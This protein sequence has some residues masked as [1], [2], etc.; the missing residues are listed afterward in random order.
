MVRTQAQERADSSSHRHAVPATQAQSGK[1]CKGNPRGRRKQI[2]VQETG[3]RALGSPFKTGTRPDPDC[4]PER[5]IEQATHLPSIGR[6]RRRGGHDT[7]KRPAY[8]PPK[9]SSSDRNTQSTIATFHGKKKDPVI[10]S[11]DQIMRT[12]SLSKQLWQSLSRRA[13]S[14]SLQRD[15]VRLTGLRDGLPAV[16]DNLQGNT[17]LTGQATWEMRSTGCT[18]P[19]KPRNEGKRRWK[20]TRLR[21]TLC[22][23]SNH[24]GFNYSDSKSNGIALLFF[25]WAYILCMA[26]LEK[27]NVSMRYTGNP[28]KVPGG[29][30]HFEE[31]CLVVDIGSVTYEEYRWWTSILSPG[32]EWRSG[33]PEQPVWAIAYTGNLKFRV[34]ARITSS[35]SLSPGPPS[36]IQA[37]SF[38]SR[39]ASMYNLESQALLS[40]A[41]ALTLPLHNETASMVQLPKPFLI[42]QDTK[43][44]S[45]SSIDREY[46]NLARYMTLSSNPMFLSSTL[47]AIFWEPGVDCNLVSPWCDPII[48]V[49]KPLVDNDSLEMLGHVLALRRP[50]IAPLWYGI[51]ACGHTKTVL[52]IIPFLQN[53]H[54]PVPSRPIPEVAAWT[55]SP[56]SFLDLPGSGP[57]LQ[58]NYQVARKDVWRLRH[59]FWDVEPEGAPFRNPPTCPWPPFGVMGVEELE[60]PVRTH[61]RCQRHHWVYTRWTW[62]LNDKI[63]VL[64]E[65]STREESWLGFEG[66]S[67]LRPQDSLPTPSYSTDHAASE[68]A[69]GDIF[70]WA[71]TEIEDTG[72]EIYTHPWVEALSDLDMGDD[73]ETDTGSSTGAKF[74]DDLWGKE[75][76]WARSVTSSLSQE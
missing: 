19:C 73:Y 40:L 18:V 13:S 63:E 39:F 33:G 23:I 17:E 8:C 41:M 1:A 32:Q 34:V 31:Q 14:L 5:P 29:E 38:L 76:D 9:R 58:G 7:S 47:W 62:L 36:S 2:E 30:S 6:K 46:G 67:H 68:R 70:R 55:G 48:E 12:F 56:Q 57:Y 28:Q 3:Q 35:E 72:R 21:P 59:E 51:A 24:S 66:E 27:Q 52:A 54:S 16:P 11:Q 22:M 65:P 74:S 26:L 50:N 20:P 42:Q 64:D 49:I 37:V 10:P 4:A 60:I 61:I 15:T 71:A 43:L 53:L 25:G 69:V 75:E 45:P 44:A